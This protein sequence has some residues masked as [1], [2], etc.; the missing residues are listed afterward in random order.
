M[1]IPESKYEKENDSTEISTNP[2]IQI[3]V[4]GI[5]NKAL[6]TMPLSLYV[7]YKYPL[8]QPKIK[9]LN[10]ITKGVIAQPIRDVPDKNTAK[11]SGK[12]IRKELLKTFITLKLVLISIYSEKKSEY[13]FVR[14][15]EDET[16]KHPIKIPRIN[17]AVKIT[18]GIC[19]FTGP[20]LSDNTP[21]LC[22]ICPPVFNTYYAK[23][24][25][26][27]PFILTILL[28]D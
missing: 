13:C 9:P 4:G 5:N 7:E 17:N 22:I 1:Q 28:R 24:W 6:N 23:E 18:N 16:E 26:S 25:T 10:E 3:S 2:N 27:I 12:D 8:K 14:L 11:Y 21:F 15:S 19:C 20:K